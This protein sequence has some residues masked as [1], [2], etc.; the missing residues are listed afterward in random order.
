MIAGYDLFP[1]GRE[2]KFSGLSLQ[3]DAG[4]EYV[5]DG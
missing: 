4:G 3:A 2:F 1:N 5:L